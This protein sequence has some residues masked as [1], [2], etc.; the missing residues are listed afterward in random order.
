M[1]I[2]LVIEVHI[3]HTSCKI[4]STINCSSPNKAITILLHPLAL[5]KQPL[6]LFLQIRRL[7][8]KFIVLLLQN[9]TFISQLFHISSHLAHSIFHLPI[10][11][12]QLLSF[13]S[14]RFKISKCLA[15]YFLFFIKRNFKL[16]S[17]LLQFFD[18]ND[19]ILGQ[20]IKN[21]KLLPLH[22]LLRINNNGLILLILLILLIG[23][24]LLISHFLNDTIF[25]GQFIL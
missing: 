11:T 21:I 18:L 15:W 19:P 16:C 25:V 20:R 1:A 14:D 9:F 10:R 13:F 17:F 23:F 12:V 2:R 3:N 5:L 22:I 7:I 8:F 4:C 6:I 24:Q